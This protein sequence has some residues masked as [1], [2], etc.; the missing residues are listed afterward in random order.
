MFRSPYQDETPPFR[1]D[2]KWHEDRSSGVLPKDNDLIIEV[3]GLDG[4]RTQYTFEQLWGLGSPIVRDSI[5]KKAFG[6]GHEVVI[7]R[8]LFGIKSLTEKGALEYS[9]L[10]NRIITKADKSRYLND[11]IFQYINPLSRVIDPKANENEDRP[12]FMPF[13]RFADSGALIGWELGIYPYPN[14][15]GFAAWDDLAGIEDLYDKAADLKICKSL[16]ALTSPNKTVEIN[17][18]IKNKQFKEEAF[19]ILWKNPVKEEFVNP[20]IKRFRENIAKRGDNIHYE[21]KPYNIGY[22]DSYIS[23]SVESPVLAYDIQ[24]SMPIKKQNKYTEFLYTK[25]SRYENPKIAWEKMKSEIESAGYGFIDLTL[26]PIMDANPQYD[27]V[28]RVV[29]DASIYEKYKVFFSSG[30]MGKLYDG[31]RLES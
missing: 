3:E 20:I 19:K 10:D 21:A 28:G 30:W 6:L 18:Q 23:V 5:G 29:S 8:S 27:F 24:I 4:K 11:Y 26:D 14:S 12:N 22:Y 25:E 16:A 7:H 15:F 9:S 1:L 2:S 17:N 13:L 31:S